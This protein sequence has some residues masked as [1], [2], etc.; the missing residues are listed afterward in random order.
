MVRDIIPNIFDLPAVR[1]PHNILTD[2]TPKGTGPTWNRPAYRDNQ[3]ILIAGSIPF[4]GDSAVI[5]YP[6]SFPVCPSRELKD[7]ESSGKD[8]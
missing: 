8:H 6:G 4:T 1:R 2:M 7:T 3:G 5:I